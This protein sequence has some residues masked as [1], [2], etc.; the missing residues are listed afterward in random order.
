VKAQPGNKEE[1][2][3]QSKGRHWTHC[4]TQQH[5][6]ECPKPATH[7]ALEQIESLG[8]ILWGQGR[9][10]IVAQIHHWFSHGFCGTRLVA[11][12]KC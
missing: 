4:H 3:R 12:K 8:S 2:W 1:E 11:G 6:A 7:L 10:L 5:E 9:I